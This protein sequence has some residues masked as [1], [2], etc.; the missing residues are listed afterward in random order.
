MLPVYGLPPGNLP[1]HP[2]LRGHLPPWGKAK[3]FLWCC[4]I[5]NFVLPNAENRAI[6][7]TSTLDIHEGLHIFAGTGRINV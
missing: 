7:H 2:A 4:Q 3:A 1:P 6:I 5:R